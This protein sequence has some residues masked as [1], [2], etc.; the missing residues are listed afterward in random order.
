MYCLSAYNK[1]NDDYRDLFW[2]SKLEECIEIG[3]SLV[4]CL[5]RDILKDKDGASYDWFEIWDDD[6]L[7]VKVISK[8][9]C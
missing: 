8:W 7:R 1:D 9:N 3:L 6:E 5:R 4:P 2:T